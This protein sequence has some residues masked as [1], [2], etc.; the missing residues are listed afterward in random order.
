[1]GGCAWSGIW[2]DFNAPDIDNY[3]YD[4]FVENPTEDTEF[5]RQP[6]GF[7]QQA[8][9]VHN[10]PKNYYTRQ[11]AGMPEDKIRRLIMNEFGFTRDGQPVYPE[12]QDTL[13][14]A[15]EPLVAHPDLKLIV[16]ID[17]GS[18]PAAAFLQKDTLGR[19]R[20]L[21][22]L[23]VFPT[24]E[25][26]LT[27]MGPTRFGGM[28]KQKLQTEY[29]HFYGHQDRLEIWADPATGAGAD[30]E[31]GDLSW[32]LIVQRETEVPV[33]PTYTNDPTIRQ[34]AV[35]GPLT[36][37]VEGKPG[38]L[39]SPKCKILRKGFN[40]GYHYRRI[41]LVGAGGYIRQEDKPNKNEYS[42]PHDG[43]QYGMLGGGEGR[44]ALH[45]QNWTPHVPQVDTDY[46]YFGG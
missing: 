14:V 31:A 15:R 16:G 18:T 29:G 22:E 42:H 40:S 27:S 8:E 30:V 7:S 17:G 35:R 38:F 19:W 43:L 25:A 4:I 45:G 24:K 21:D 41:N 37:I 39:L 44:V 10:L 20:C 28:L 13:H 3:C 6:S 26:M 2:C 12:F 1:L 5:F 34:E 36:R 11:A 46:A 32:R 9:N 33:R 23:V